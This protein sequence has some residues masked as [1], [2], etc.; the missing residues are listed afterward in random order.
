MR[1]RADYVLETYITPACERAS[2]DPVRADGDTGQ[3]IV[4]GTT[5]AL[6]NAP[7][8]V[9][10]MGPAP[11]SACAS[12]EGPGCWNA[13]VMIEIG[14]RLA[15]RLPLIFLCDQASHYASRRLTAATAR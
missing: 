7:M 2:H 12:G 3:N 1:K 10:Y 13:N 11:N 5:T 9:A 8:T 4:D 15:S 6:Q 14:Y